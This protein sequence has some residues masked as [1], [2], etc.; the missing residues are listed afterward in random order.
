MNQE[1]QLE[2]KKVIFTI[3]QHNDPFTSLGIS[4]E[5][6]NTRFLELGSAIDKYY[7]EHPEEYQLLIKRASVGGYNI[8][9][10]KHALI[11][12]ISL[13]KGMVRKIR[14]FGG[15]K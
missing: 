2:D 4:S 13:L 7:K 15:K 10:L 8:D 9:R 6:A 11:Y 12:L 14:D 1:E 5:E 3:G